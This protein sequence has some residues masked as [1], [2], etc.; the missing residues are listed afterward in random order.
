MSR[1]QDNSSNVHF[2]L[3]HILIIF[4][5]SISRITEQIRKYGLEPKD[6]EPDENDE[7]YVPNKNE[8]KKRG[9]PEK[10]FE[11]LGQRQK[12]ARLQPTL[13]FVRATA[14]KET[15]SV[16][17]TLGKIGEMEA[18]QNVDRPTAKMFR[19]IADGEDPFAH[20]T[21]TVE[22]ALALKVGS[23]T[24]WKN[25]KFTLTEN[26]NQSYSCM[27]FCKGVTFLKVKFSWTD[28]NYI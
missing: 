18:N 4:I 10:S 16:N 26:S 11:E 28:S 20:R 12:R 23:T 15:L 1:L 19:R 8:E 14:E 9:R 17:Q 3:K 21:M 24:V 25:E 7:E 5:D 27:I 13:D 22:R 2:C 6:L